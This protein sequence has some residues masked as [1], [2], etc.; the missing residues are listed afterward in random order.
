LQDPPPKCA[1]DLNSPKAQCLKCA[2]WLVLKASKIV[3]RSD[4]KTDE[5]PQDAFI[6]DGK[7]PLVQAAIQMSGREWAERSIA[8][9]SSNRKH[10]RVTTG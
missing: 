3:A 6:V 5:G 4:M 10:A 8:I 7:P 1:V 9:S 2:G